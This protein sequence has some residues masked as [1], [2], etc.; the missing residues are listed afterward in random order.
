MSDQHKLMSSK[1]CFLIFA[2]LLLPFFLTGSLF[3]Q[4]PFPL[5]NWWENN[6]ARPSPIDGKKEVKDFLESLN[7]QGK[8]PFTEEDAIRLVLESNL[9]VTVDRLDPRMAASDIQSAARAFDPK[10]TFIGGA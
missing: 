4:T 9:E 8:L 10:L 2:V 3:A 1:S 5:P 6:I 7:K